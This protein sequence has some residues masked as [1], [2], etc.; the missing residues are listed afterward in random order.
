MRVLR[1]ILKALGIAL[2]LLLLTAQPMAAVALATAL[3]LMPVL[4]FGL[5]VVPR[6]LW[7]AADPDQH[8]V[9]SAFGRAELLQRP[10]PV[11]F[12]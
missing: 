11:S 1:Q 6:S 10:P 5:I 3:I 12:L 9:E 2:C 4:L 8:F 7:P